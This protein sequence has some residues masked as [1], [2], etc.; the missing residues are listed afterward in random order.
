VTLVAESTHDEFRPAEP[1]GT[2]PGLPNL[3]T[4]RYAPRGHV[5]SP[6]Q[7]LV[8]QLVCCGLADK[9]V[10]HLLSLSCSTVKSHMSRAIRE[11]GLVRRHQVV[12]Y[13]FENDLFDPETTQARIAQRSAARQRRRSSSPV[14]SRRSA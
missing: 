13:I 6:I 9:E 4:F 8:V 7:E 1:R 11:M 5:L 14:P 10:A 2:S 3:R 12:R